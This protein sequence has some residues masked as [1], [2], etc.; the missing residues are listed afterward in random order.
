M[1]YLK[2]YEAIQENFDKEALKHSLKKTYSHIV[3][4]KIQ[5]LYQ[6]LGGD[7]IFSPPIDVR[8]RSNRGYVDFLLL[9]IEK[10][11]NSV[12]IN[13]EYRLEGNIKWEKD[14]TRVIGTYDSFSINLEEAIQERYPDFEEWYKI[15]KEADKFNF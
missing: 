4:D 3:F 15:R 14:F 1:K 5:Y 13:Y 8:S 6:Y 12:Y 2:A 9:K 10:D 11:D 7:T